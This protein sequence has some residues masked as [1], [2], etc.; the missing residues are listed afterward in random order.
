MGRI[1][2]VSRAICVIIVALLVVDL[3]YGYT[4]GPPTNEYV[5]IALHVL[6][7][8]LVFWLAAMFNS[9]RIQRLQ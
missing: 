6:A 8:I 4:F 3:L 2:R 5:A 9:W 1:G 7:V